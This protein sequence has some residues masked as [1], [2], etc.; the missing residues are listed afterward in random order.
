MKYGDYYRWLLDR[1]NA[2]PGAFYCRYQRLIEKLYLTK[3]EWHFELDANRA[4][5]GQGLRSK[6]A[7]EEGVNC[8]DSSSPC[9]VLEM[10][11]ALAESMSDTYGYSIAKWFWE[12]IVNL[13]LNYCPDD[14]YDEHE[15]KDILYAWM[16]GKYSRNGEGSPFPLENYA[17]D[18]RHLQL[19]DLM[20]N[21]ICE[22]YPINKDWLN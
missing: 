13:G 7:Y 21:Y 20:N 5:A 16:D 9:S 11:E 1:I 4:V 3:Y 19:W 10:L 15:V 14:Q 22:K 12:M 18:A 8:E 6:F 17:G 2:G